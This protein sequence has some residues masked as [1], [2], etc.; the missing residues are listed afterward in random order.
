MGFRL[1]PGT[2]V[3]RSEVWCCKFLVG[4]WEKIEMVGQRFSKHLCVDFGRSLAL[5]RKKCLADSSGRKNEAGLS[6]KGRLLNSFMQWW[7]SSCFK[8]SQLKK[9]VSQL[10]SGVFIAA[11]NYWVLQSI[12]PQLYLQ[13]RPWVDLDWNSLHLWV[14]SSHKSHCVSVS[15]SAKWRWWE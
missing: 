13:C 15:S 7:R 10:A 6:Q 3:R 12:W 8:V 14:L 5:S 1:T 2:M 9:K 11:L 4:F